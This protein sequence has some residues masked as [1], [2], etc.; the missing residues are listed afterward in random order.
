MEPVAWKP[1]WVNKMRLEPAVGQTQ[2]L[3]RFT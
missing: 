2:T 1:F 3:F